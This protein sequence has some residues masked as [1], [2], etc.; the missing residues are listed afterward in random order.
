MVL[1]AIVPEADYKINPASVGH[2]LSEPFHYP[3]DIL[4]I[5]FM[6]QIVKHLIKPREAYSKTPKFNKNSEG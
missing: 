1:R 5:L 3:E 6:T 2:L 4:G